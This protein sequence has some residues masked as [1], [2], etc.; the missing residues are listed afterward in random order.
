MN[1]LNNHNLLTR[2]LS[3]TRKSIRSLTCWF[4]IFGG[5]SGIELEFNSYHYDPEKLKEDPVKEND[6]LMDAIR[7]AVY[8]HNAKSFAMP[9][10][11]IGLVRPF[12]GMG[13][14]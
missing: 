5:R 8:N 11:T 9:G 14:T 2:P 1:F 7:Y 10:P 6:H 4:D 12:P 3:V 13:S